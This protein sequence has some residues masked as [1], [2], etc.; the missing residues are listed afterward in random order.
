MGTR[1][2]IGSRSVLVGVAVALCSLAL[3]G[4]GSGHTT[5]STTSTTMT[6]STTTT[7]ATV[8]CSSHPSDAYARSVLADSP[9]AYYRLDQS[10]GTVMCDSSRLADNGTYAQWVQ[11]GVSGAIA[12][13]A[14]AAA[15]T[16]SSGIG[17]GGAQSGLVGDHS[18]TLEA[19]ER[20]S[21][22]HNQSLVSMGQAGEGNVAGLSTWTSTTGDGQASQ[23]VLDLYVGVGN[24]GALPIWNTEAV[25]VNLWDGNWHYLAITFDAKT[26]MATGFVDG[27]DLG[28]LKPITS[29]DL[30]S[31][32]IRVGY[33]VD[34]LLN[35][36]VVGD[37]D[38]V[39]VYPTALSA[40]RIAAHY[41]ASGAKISPTS[42]TT[43]PSVR[44]TRVAL[45]T[46]NPSSYDCTTNTK[47]K[48]TEVGYVT[49]GVSSAS[50]S[51]DIHLQT[52]QPD[53]L[54]GVFMQ[55]SPGS[56]PQVQANGGSFTSESQGRATFVST[57]PRVAGA[58]T[59]FVQL[60]NGT[61]PSE[62]TS[63]RVSANGH[64]L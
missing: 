19:W 50:F 56:C 64:A 33:W 15:G 25:G 12:G 32:A 3:A 43:M 18:F 34:D 10:S 41:L 52:G 27:H 28:A 31:S 22:A 1:I 11:L 26:D 44:G 35:P 61:V 60:V 9:V 4:C 57:M 7:A 62:Y 38:E 48:G 51:A 59:F 55:Q 39:A 17:T 30:T 49:L 42:T 21:S 46:I 6:P 36:N 58:T 16:P 53:T 2:G 24:A 45:G 20:D 5:T 47:E 54:Y 8:A 63:D 40:S 37:E 14:A 29:I 23:L 13:D